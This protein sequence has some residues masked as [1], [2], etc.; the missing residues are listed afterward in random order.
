MG[1]CSSSCVNLELSLE[2]R[3]DSLGVE[4]ET[5]LVIPWEYRVEKGHLVMLVLEDIAQM[6]SFTCDS[7]GGVLQIF[8][9]NI[10]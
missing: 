4:T 2:A 5:V 8:E 10:W 9:L 1:H 7:E 3:S 6:R